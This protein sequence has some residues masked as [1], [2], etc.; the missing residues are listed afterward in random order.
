MESPL[1]EVV[2]ED[3]SEDILSEQ[4]GDLWGDNSKTSH[5]E[6][7]KGTGLGLGYWIFEEHKTDCVARMYWIRENSRKWGQKH[8]QQPDSTIS[9]ATEKSLDFLLAIMRIIKGFKWEM[10]PILRFRKI[11]LAALWISLWCWRWLEWRAR[12]VETEH[13]VRRPF[14]QHK[15]LVLREGA[16]VW[17]GR[18]H[19][20]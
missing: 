1:A 14:S 17:W 19:V 3:F 9:E 7:Q 16:C 13:I 8:R 15:L 12:V 6:E 11:N 10:T 4:N 5:T 20:K 2:G 18:R